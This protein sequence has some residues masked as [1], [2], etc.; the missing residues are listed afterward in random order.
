MDLDGAFVSVDCHCDMA[1]IALVA[2]LADLDVRERHAGKG[3]NAVIAF[4]TIDCQM[5]VTQFLQGCRRELVIHAFGFLKTQDI[6]SPVTFE[7][8]NQFDA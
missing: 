6:R 4:L 7:L 2:E 1:G 5:L 3:G 8:L